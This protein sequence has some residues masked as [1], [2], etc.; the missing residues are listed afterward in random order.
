[1]ISTNFQARRVALFATTALGLT[2]AASAVQAQD[3]TVQLGAVQVEGQGT[4]DANPYADPAAPYKADRLSSS[5][6][7]EPVLNTPRSETII[8]KE[9]LQDTG[10]TS[11]R[12]VV[13]GTAGVTLGS[14]EGGNAF[15]DRF[16]IRGFDARNDVFVDGV[17]DPGVM[18]REN[19]DTEQ[20]E[21]LKGPASTF[22]GR[23]TTGGALNIVTKQARDGTFYDFEATGGLSDNT[24]RLTADVNYAIDPT[25]DVRVNGMIQNANAAGRNYTT[26]NRRGIAGAVTWRAS[27]TLTITGNYSYSYR[28]GLPDFGVP[29]NPLARR[30]DTSGDVSR[31]TYYGAVNRDF[32]Q[33]QQAQGGVDITWVATDW[34]TFENKARQSHSL[35]NYIG[36][37]PENPS[38]TGATAPFSS[39]TTKFSGYTQLNAQS[40]YEPVTVL[41]DQPQA[42]FF[43]DVGPVR[44][45]AVVGGEFSSEHVSIAKYS[46]L[47]SELTTGVA[48]F[49]SGFAPIVPVG[50]P[51]NTILSASKPTLGTPTNVYKINTNAGYVMD[52]ANYKDFVILNGGIRFDAYGVTS[53]NATASQYANSNITSYNVGLVVKP[54]EEI[55]LY[56]AFATGADPVG[57]EVDASASAYGGLAPTQPTGQVFAPMKSMAYEVGVKWSLFDD[58]LLATAA[59]FRTDVTNA[60]ETAPAGIPGFTSGQIY[61]NAAYRVEGFDLGVTGNITDDWSVQA[62]AVIMTPKITRSINPNDVG[63]QLANIAPESFNVLTKY[64]VRDWLAVGGQALANS[65]TKGGSLLAA[66]GGVAYPG[67]PYPTAVPS[68]WRFDMFAEGVVTKNILVR[69]NVQNIFDKTYYNALYQSAVP[70]VQ[71]APGRSVYLSAEV[72]L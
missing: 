12:D 40:Q 68:Y 35:L 42:T 62:G 47:S 2:M 8:T 4:A 13:T 9:A 3:T 52:T 63:L 14:G 25:L 61:P 38:A 33:S 27:D 17:R 55:S 5:K 65:Q 10:A 36:T 43:F 15:G 45:T 53:S 7:T 44:N 71:I 41:V 28:Y 18:V 29:Y 70:F 72:K 19:F 39:S 11:L 57:D 56:G 46:G 16:F 50:S 37:I 67:T 69:L 23:G 31:N 64:D 54:A 1:M 30:P 34:L 49:T 58:H 32:T 59:A 24:K 48:A 21:I 6:F 66:N 22:A 20:V 26:D 60:R 51:T